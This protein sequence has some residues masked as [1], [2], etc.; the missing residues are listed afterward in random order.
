MRGAR[1]DAREAAAA[2]MIGGAAH[3]AL[4]QVDLQLGGVHNS[5]WAEPMRARTQDVVAEGPAD[6]GDERRGENGEDQLVHGRRA[7]CAA[8]DMHAGAA[9]KVLLVLNLMSI[10]IDA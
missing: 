9:Y 4:E 1:D 8:E 2:K 7:N 3:L 5:R 10:P 6:D